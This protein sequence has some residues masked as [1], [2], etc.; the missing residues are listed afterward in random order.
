[1]ATD[2]CTIVDYEDGQV[3]DYTLNQWT[4]SDP[5][6]NELQ[7]VRIEDVKTALTTRVG[8]NPEDP[9]DSFDAYRYNTAYYFKV[10]DLS[11]EN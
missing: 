1:M 10:E 2:K 5:L 8:L 9:N 11:D 6:I 4:Y 3:Y 7:S